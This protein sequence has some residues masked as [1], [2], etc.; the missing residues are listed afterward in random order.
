MNGE[1]GNTGTKMQ[2]ESRK[3]DS[4][5][6]HMFSCCLSENLKLYTHTPQQGQEEENYL[7]HFS[8]IGQ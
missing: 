5:R 6:G 2:M 4:S 7:E 8:Q 3:E 1:K